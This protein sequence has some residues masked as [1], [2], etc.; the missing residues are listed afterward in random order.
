MVL[1]LD[2]TLLSDRRGAIYNLE[3]GRRKE[4]QFVQ[5]IP[6]FEVL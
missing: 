6:I 2:H 5:N 4:R 1:V 3:A